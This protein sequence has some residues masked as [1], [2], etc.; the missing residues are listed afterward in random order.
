MEIDQSILDT[1]YTEDATTEDNDIQ[2]SSDT[3]EKVAAFLNKDGFLDK[4]LEE[5]YEALLLYI[6]EKNFQHITTMNA[7]EQGKWLVKTFGPKAD[8]VKYKSLSQKTQIPN[9]LISLIVHVEL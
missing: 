8:P 6:I 2:G 5:Q 7:M 3:D 4:Q 9:M 1:F